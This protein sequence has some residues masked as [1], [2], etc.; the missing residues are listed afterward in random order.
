MTEKGS[1]I[2]R[3]KSDCMFHSVRA[4]SKVHK[5]LGWERRAGAGWGTRQRLL[6]LE[7]VSVTPG[8]R[9]KGASQAG[10][11]NG[12]ERKKGTPNGLE[13]QHRGDTEG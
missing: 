4:I 11:G 8:K 1:G 10:P 7:R 13:G 3:D 9:S 12:K 2:I 6:A 5:G